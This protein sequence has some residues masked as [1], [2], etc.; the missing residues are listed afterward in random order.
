LRAT[1]AA[2]PVRAL[3]STPSGDRFYVALDGEPAVQVLDRYSNSVASTVELPD[4]ATEL[5]MDPLGRYVLARA[6][7]GD[8]AWVVAVGTARVIGTVNTDW[9]DDLPFVAPDGAIALVEKNDV[10]LVDGE[11]LRERS[12]VS[13]GAR[14]FWH[15]IVWNGL[16]PRAGDLDPSATAADSDSVAAAPADSADTTSAPAPPAPKTPPDTANGQTVQTPITG[17]PPR[18]PIPRPAPPRI[19][20]D[21]PTAAAQPPRARGWVVSFAAFVSEAPA[22]AR[23]KAISVEGQQARVAVGQTNGTAVYRVVLGPYPTKADAE[24]VGRASRESFWVYEGNP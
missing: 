9:R 8:S 13:G 21:T 19:A 23:A 24:R 15:R 20:V 4:A 12:V 1:A 3:A 16:R 14:D 2:A 6:A 7:N 5:R 22:L 18:A 11:T 17:R 10:R